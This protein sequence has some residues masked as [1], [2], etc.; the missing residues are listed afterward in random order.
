MSRS[1]TLQ[2][3]SLQPTKHITERQSNGQ[4]NVRS[5]TEARSNSGTVLANL[6]RR[7][8]HRYRS[9]ASEVNQMGSKPRRI[10]AGRTCVR[11]DWGTVV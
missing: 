9:E 4:N 5:P 7:E 6:E 10:R 1:E 3:R 2:P 11:R 8:A